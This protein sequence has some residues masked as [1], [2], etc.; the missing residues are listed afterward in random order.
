MNNSEYQ[1]SLAYH[2]REGWEIV[3]EIP[4]GA[5]LRKKKTLD[6]GS[7][8]FIALGILTIPLFGFGLLLILI[9]VLNY[10]LFV[11]DKTKF[12]SANVTFDE[13]EIAHS[14]SGNN[15]GAAI[16]SLIIPG[17]GQFMQGRRKEGIT[18]FLVALIAWL[19]L[20]G[21]ILHTAACI[22]AAVWDPEKELH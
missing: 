13:Q 16:A 21:W 20:L 7:G 12:I 10:T 3:S 11:K 1:K 8:V 17:L 14:W 22:H 9:G 5:Q 18:F 2:L 4:S 6:P 15:T 19:F